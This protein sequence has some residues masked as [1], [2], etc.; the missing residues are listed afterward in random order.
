MVAAAEIKSTC[1]EVLDRRPMR[2]FWL[3]SK[4]STRGD[5]YPFKPLPSADNVEVSPSAGEGN[6]PAQPPAHGHDTPWWYDPDP[7]DPSMGAQ[8]TW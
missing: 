8:G 4:L 2:S 6:V 3:D 1:K 5:T 7:S